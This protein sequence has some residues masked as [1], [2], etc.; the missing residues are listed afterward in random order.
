MAEKRKITKKKENKVKFISDPSPSQEGGTAID[1]MTDQ[2][3]QILNVQRQMVELKKSV[4]PISYRKDLNGKIDKTKIVYSS[5]EYNQSFGGVEEKNHKRLGD[6]EQKDLAQLDPYVSAIISTRCA[7]ASIIGRKSDSKFDKGT[8]VYEI[9]PLKLEDFDNRNEFEKEQSIRKNQMNAIFD[10][11]FNCGTSDESVIDTAFSGF[12]PT[13]KKCTLPEFITAQVRNLLTFGR[14]GTQ[15]FRNEDGLPVMW[16]PV[17]IETIKPLAYEHDAYLTTG[18]EVA[19]QSTQNAKEYNELPEKLRPIA[20]VQQVNG[21]N[22]NFFTEDDLKIDYFQ[23][24]A[25]FDLRGYPLSPL[26]LA[27]YMVFTHQQTLG[28]L[29]NQFIKGIGSKGILVL[30]S[31]DPASSLSGEDL[32]DLRRSFHNYLTR[33]DNSAVTPMLSGPVRANYLSL[34]PSVKD[35]EF[36]QVEEHVIRS[37]CSSFQISPHEMGYGHLSQNQGGL[38]SQNRQEEIIRGEEKGLRVLLD[39]IYDTIN[40]LLCESFPEIKKLYRITYVG[41]GEDTRDS[42]TQRHI[43]ELQTTATLSG[44]WADSEKNE[45]VPYGGNVPLAPLFHSNVVRYMKYGVFMEEFF[46]EK[47]ASKNPDYDFIIDPSLNQAYLQ[48]KMMKQQQM[49]GMQQEPENEQQKQERT[50][51]ASLDNN[52]QQN[53]INDNATKSQQNEVS[54]SRKNNQSLISAYRNGDLHKSM[55]F[56][57]SE[58]INAHQDDKED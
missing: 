57:F 11:V 47:D 18:D 17:P 50:E 33:N 34:N 3:K 35:M 43:G 27:I 10:W 15:I 5:G 24:Q 37:L 1:D 31:T 53:Q 44:L 21:S 25:L 58:W 2:V 56:Y 7:Q 54:E 23:K 19:D 14:C 29:R 32:E 39:I 20:F 4:K 49:Q 8:R 13:F 52:A 48:N 16:R 36:L 6:Q 41:V 51:D 9:S 42:V 46:G 12:D 55:E 38:T 45:P 28:Y 30:E 22:V 40:A 26:E